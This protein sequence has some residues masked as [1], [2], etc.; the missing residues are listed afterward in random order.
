MNTFTNYHLALSKADYE[1]GLASTRYKEE[2]DKLSY[3][4]VLPIY[5]KVQSLLLRYGSKWSW[6]KRPKYYKN[7]AALKK[8]LNHEETR[9]FLFYRDG[10][11][12]GYCLV[13]VPEKLRNSKAENPHIIE[14]ENI[15]LD[16]KETGNGYGRFF[17]KEVF[18][19]LFKT[20]DT[21][22]LSSRSTNHSGVIPFY[23]RMGM[24][25]IHIEKNLPDDL[26]IEEKITA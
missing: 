21:I 9:L 25:I 8:R 13:S 1:S 2:S 10:K 19:D 12:I 7:S 22:Y 3:K 4:M 23:L 20:Y 24:S 17:L 26:V 15:A 5:K 11:E 16:Y 14:I 6:D 18:A